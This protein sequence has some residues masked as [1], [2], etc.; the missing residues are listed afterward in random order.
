MRPFFRQGS[1][2]SFGS[3][4]TFA[5]GVEGEAPGGAKINEY[6]AAWNVTNA[7]QV[8]VI[9]VTLVSV[10]QGKNHKTQYFLEF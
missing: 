7:I 4:S 1:V 10:P 2:Q 8:S 6:Q 9:T 3:D 5:G